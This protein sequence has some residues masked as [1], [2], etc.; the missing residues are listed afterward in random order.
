MDLGGSGGNDPVAWGNVLTRLCRRCSNS[1][2]LYFAS[3]KSK[4]KGE[5]EG[6]AGEYL[7]II[8]MGPP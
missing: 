6:L 7:L 4:E 3:E 5:T 8:F 2:Y 1:E